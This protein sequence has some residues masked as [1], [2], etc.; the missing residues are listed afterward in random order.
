MLLANVVLCY[1]MHLAWA[2]LSSPL[3]RVRATRNQNDL[4]DTQHRCLL[5][6][7]KVGRFLQVR[8]FRARYSTPK[9]EGRS[10]SLIVV[11]KALPSKLRPA[12]VDHGRAL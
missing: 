2:P 8:M 12:F 1:C 11:L 4:K 10:D 3:A 6:I 7:E 9:E 5:E